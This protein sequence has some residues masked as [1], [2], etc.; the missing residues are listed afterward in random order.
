MH[1]FHDTHKQFP[2]AAIFGPDGKP[3][4]SWRVLLLPY[5]EQIALYDQYR[6]DEPWDGPNNKKLLAAMPP[7]Y[8]DPLYGEDQG[9]FPH[10]AVVT[11]PE[12]MAVRGTVSLD[13]APVEGATVRFKPKAGGREAVGVTD[14]NGRFALTPSRPN[15][16]V[17]K[18]MYGVT[19]SK[20]VDETRDLLPKKY[21][22]PDTSALPVEVTAGANEFTFE[23]R[24]D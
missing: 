20:K 21:A 6:F 15:D 18:G 8:R 12:T 4:H 17:A 14:A 3:W 7:V 2:P 9:H 16:G 22:D 24:S 1:N 23:L 19:V 10:Y 5:L 13:G 11:G